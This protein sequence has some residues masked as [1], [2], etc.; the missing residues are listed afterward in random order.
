MTYP[1]RDWRASASGA[2]ARAAG[3]PARGR[4]RV[5]DAEHLRLRGFDR[6]CH[7]RNRSEDREQEKSVAP[8]LMTKHG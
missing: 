7:E 5:L 4:D 3:P 8:K 6:E 1:I 2:R